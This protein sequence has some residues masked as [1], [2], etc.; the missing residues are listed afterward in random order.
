M[1]RDR[2]LEKSELV[3]H[4]EENTCRYAARERGTDEWDDMLTGVPRKERDRFLDRQRFVDGVKWIV[5]LLVIADGYKLCLIYKQVN[6]PYS[7]SLPSNGF[8]F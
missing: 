6:E 5:D 1:E 8:H 4:W 7:D 3:Q 2:S